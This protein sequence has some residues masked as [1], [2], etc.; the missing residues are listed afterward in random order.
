MTTESIENMDCTNE[1]DPLVQRFRSW[2]FT[3]DFKS[4]W[5]QRMI[6]LRQQYAPRAF[7]LNFAFYG[8]VSVYKFVDA[9][10]KRLVAGFLSSLGT[11]CG[12]SP[13]TGSSPAITTTA[14]KA[15]IEA[16]ANSDWAS[17]SLAALFEH[18]LPDVMQHH[19]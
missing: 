14:S 15:A 3:Q 11:S 18:L 5:C 16:L 1:H 12:T 6:L 17:D 10:V 4:L 7:N 9:N 13:T 19:Y 2:E 8:V